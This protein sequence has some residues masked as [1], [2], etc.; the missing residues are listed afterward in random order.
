MIYHHE[1]QEECSQKF[2]IVGKK[3]SPQL[4]AAQ[5][6]PAS[7]P[8]IN[9][10]DR[11]CRILKAKSGSPPGIIVIADPLKHASALVKVDSRT[12]RYLGGPWF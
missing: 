4:T 1:I 3:P 7:Q 8:V 9:V 2:A 5:L 10:C 11:W 6:Q 12:T